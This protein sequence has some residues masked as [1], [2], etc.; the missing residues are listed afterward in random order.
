MQNNPAGP[1]Y[2]PPPQGYM[3]PGT[4]PYAPPL[5]ASANSPRSS[6]EPYNND[7][8]AAIDPALAAAGHTSAHD[9]HGT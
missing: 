8:G 3:P 7:Y 6:T 4:H 2:P 9:P 5:S 1:S